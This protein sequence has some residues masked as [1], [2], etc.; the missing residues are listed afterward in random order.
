[1]TPGDATVDLVFAGDVTATL[2]GTAGRC[3]GVTGGFSVTIQ[4]A[5]LG[6]NPSFE[7]AMV[8]LGEEDWEKPP[9]VMNLKEG[10][11]KSYVWKKT[12]G[13]VTAARDRSR[14]DFDVLLTNVVGTETVTVKGSVLCP[15][16]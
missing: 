15:P 5:E 10:D 6:V 12:T 8:I 3:G 7:L 14:A 13:A 4:S 9:T 1:M 16:G 11:K 2:K